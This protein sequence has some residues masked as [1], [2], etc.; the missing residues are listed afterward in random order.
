LDEWSRVQARFEKPTIVG[1]R[2]LG[3]LLS[4]TSIWGWMH[5]VQELGVERWEI[6]GDYKLIRPKRDVLTKKIFSR[7]PAV[8]Y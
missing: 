8:L 5:D 1:D 4:F 3:W 6:S 7:T 2:S